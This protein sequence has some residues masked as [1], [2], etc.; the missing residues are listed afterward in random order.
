MVTGSQLAKMATV[1]GQP[2]N[3]ILPILWANWHITS[4][5]S[6]MFGY[7]TSSKRIPGGSQ[8]FHFK[9]HNRPPPFRLWLW[10]PETFPD[11]SSSAK[12]GTFPCGKRQ[13]WTHLGLDGWN[14]LK[15]NEPSV[16]DA[17]LS[18]IIENFDSQPSYAFQ[19]LRHHR[20]N[21]CGDRTMENSGDW[22]KPWYISSLSGMETMRCQKWIG[23]PGL[24]IN[25]CKKF[26]HYNRFR[27]CCQCVDFCPNQNSWGIASS[28]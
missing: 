13:Q 10:Y 26:G 7:C 8:Y 20:I 16:D 22:F 6:F 17:G 18:L 27:L 24:G 28:P 3:P 21:H 19:R 15:P 23:R 11:A 25:V 14:C 4:P 1:P 5:V 2:I 9:T 12:G